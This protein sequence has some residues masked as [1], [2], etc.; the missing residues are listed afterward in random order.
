[1]AVFTGTSVD[2]AVGMSV[3]VGRMIGVVEGADIVEPMTTGV[4][5]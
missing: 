3:L 5:L 4:G 2:V 1:M